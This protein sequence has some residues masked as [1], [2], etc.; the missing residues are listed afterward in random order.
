MLDQLVER[1][2]RGE[3]IGQVAN[4]LGIP[5]TTARRHMRSAMPEMPSPRAAAHEYSLSR[6]TADYEAYCH[7]DDEREM[8]RAYIDSGS[9]YEASQK[10]CIA[11]DA[12]YKRLLAVRARAAL[13]GFAPDAG[14]T[15]PAPDAFMVKGV[16]TLYNADGEIAAQWVKTKP[17]AEAAKAAIEA[18][19]CAMAENIPRA[20][21]VPAPAECSSKLAVQYTITDYHYGMLAWHEEGGDNWDLSIA[22]TTLNRAFSHLIATAPDAE[23]GIVAQLG[24]FLHSDGMLPVTPTHGHILDQDGR[25]AKVV[26]S[27]VRALR[28]VVDMALRKHKK[29][30]VLMAEGNHDM[31]SSI[32]LRTLFAA[33]YEQEPRVE[34]I[35]SP[36]PFYCIQHGQVMLGFHHGHLKKNG[37]LPLMFATQYPQIW[38]AT[39]HRYAHAGHRHHSEEKE[40]SG[41]TVIQHST[42][43]ARDAHAARGG[44][45]T[46]RQMQSITYH[47]DHG[48]VA[49]SVVRPEMLISG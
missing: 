46:D 20:V 19:L 28:R 41:L 42:L 39:R 49:R 3:L 14:M 43:A 13:K 30:I 8:L 10:L 16:S 45:H 4:D 38:G 23:I 24:D 26:R 47:A 29:V 32:W 6:M 48:I 34:V 44:W 31:A 40:H 27:A 35:T 9:C 5:D 37:G 1:V 17:D 22:E 33:L 2:L 7:D 25:F 36:L 15:R 18:A 21:P 12:L 11:A